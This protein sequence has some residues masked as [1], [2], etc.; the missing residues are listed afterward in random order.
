M[1]EYNELTSS[2]DNMAADMTLYPVFSSQTFLL[3]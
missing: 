3:D 2:R 1:S